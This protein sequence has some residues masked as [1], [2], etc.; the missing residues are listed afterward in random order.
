LPGETASGKAIREKYREELRKLRAYWPEESV[1]LEEVANG[2][3]LIRFHGGGTHSFNPDEVS[4]LLKIT[5]VY[6]R[7]HIHLP[8][9]LRYEK[10]G[11][12]AYYYV[13]GGSWQR[14]LAEIMLRGS[15]TY[16]GIG[17]LKVSEFQEIARKYPSLIFVSIG[18]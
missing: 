9:L 1:S 12:V 6:L 16:T 7:A 15:Y 3:L 10:H 8:L 17:M 11:N 4:T 2:R 5:P 18:L 14:R 13:L